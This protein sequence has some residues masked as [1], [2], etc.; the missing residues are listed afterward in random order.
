MLDFTIRPEESDQTLIS[1]LKKRL[2]TTPLSLIYKLFRS[3]KVKVDGENVRYYHYRLKAG[4]KVLVYDNSLQVVVPNTTAGPPKNSQ[5]KLPVV[6]ENK[7]VL[8]VVK[9]HGISMPELDEAARYYFY[10]QDPPKYQ[11]L[12]QK[13]FVFVALHRLDKL[14]K[15]L[16]IYPKNPVG[17]RILYNAINNKEKITKKYLAVCE[18]YS[19]K[20]IPNYI[21]GFLRK[22]EKFKKMEFAGESSDFQA[23]HC[24]LEV[25][26]RKENANYQLLEIT[27]HTGRKHQIRAILSYFGLPIIGD[28][29]YGSQINRKNEICLLAYQLEFHNLPSPLT[30]LN[31]RIFSP[32]GW[33]KEFDQLLQK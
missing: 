2:L 31:G 12:I 18:N 23:K 33:E 9:E 22:N 19:N 20:T 15:G 13:Y 32:P 26:K 24:A 29:K 25:T 8:I 4:E 5:L 21:A 3:K 11:E 17:K 1:F 6:Y 27:L 10:Q 16:V 28:K 30:D 7:N 14:T